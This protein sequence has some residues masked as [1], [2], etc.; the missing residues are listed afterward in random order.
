[1]RILCIILLFPTLAYAQQPLTTEQKIGC[2][3]GIG[4]IK[5]MALS[6]E[7][8]QMQQQIASL[9]AQIEHLQKKIDSQ[10]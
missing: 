7:K 8:E 1:M 2:E 10:K 3:L 5:T 4:I 6:S 9:T